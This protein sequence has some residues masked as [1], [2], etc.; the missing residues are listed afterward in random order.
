MTRNE[1]V[2]YHQIHPLKL[3]VDIATGLSTTALLWFHLWIPAAA[4]ALAPSVVITALLIRFADLE[5]LKASTFGRYVAFH[6]GAVAT[7]VR[8]LGQVVMWLA[9]WWQLGWVVALGAVMIVAGWTW[10]LPKW[11]ASRASVA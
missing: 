5:R 10:S 2:L 11:R 7:T 3:A 6:M 9:A 4:I 1:Q 8:A